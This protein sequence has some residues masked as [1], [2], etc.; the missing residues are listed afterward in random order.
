M[1]LDQFDKDVFTDMTLRAMQM[2][3]D[4]FVDY[5]EKGKQDFPGA[6]KGKK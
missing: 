6:F 5:V 4:Q 1:V 2:C 3:V